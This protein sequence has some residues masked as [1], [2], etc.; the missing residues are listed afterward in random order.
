MK[1]REELIKEGISKIKKMGFQYVT[2]E[3]IFYDEVYRSY[4]ESML[5]SKTGASNYLDEIIQELIDEINIKTK[6]HI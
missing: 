5:T 1:T 6:T 4:F 3:N 2:S